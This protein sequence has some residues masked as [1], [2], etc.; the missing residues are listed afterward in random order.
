MMTA[1]LTCW[2][3][4]YLQQLITPPYLRCPTRFAARSGPKTQLTNFC[5]S[6]PYSAPELVLGAGTFDIIFD[7]FSRISR[8]RPTPHALCAVVFLLSMLIGS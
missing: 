6:L 4:C 5:G 3:T 2:T 1:C 7:Q 8:L